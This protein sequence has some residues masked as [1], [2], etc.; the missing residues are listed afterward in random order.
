MWQNIFIG[1]EDGSK[2]A[3]YSRHGTQKILASQNYRFLILADKP[4]RPDIEGIEIDLKEKPDEE[5]CGMKTGIK[6]KTNDE[7]DKGDGDK[8]RNLQKHA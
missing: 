4:H 8:G 1:F 7:F 6:R 5:E 2:S 3:R